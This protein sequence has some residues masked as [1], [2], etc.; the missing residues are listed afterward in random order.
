[1]ANAWCSDGFGLATTHAKEVAAHHSIPILSWSH[2]DLAVVISDAKPNMLRGIEPTGNKR[3]LAKWPA[4]PQ[5]GSHVPGAPVRCA[6]RS[7]IGETEEHPCLGL[8]RRRGRTRSVRLWFQGVGQLAGV[9]AAALG[10]VRFAAAFA[11]ELGGEGA[12]ELAGGLA[13]LDGFG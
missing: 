12:D 11:A 7:L 5:G 6:V 8:R 10:V 9:A 1:M 4:P 13:G 3:T 2:G